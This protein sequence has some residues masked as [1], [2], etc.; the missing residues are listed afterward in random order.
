MIKIDFSKNNEPTVSNKLFKLNMILYC[1]REKIEWI[2]GIK[3]PFWASII[4]TNRCNLKCSHCYSK[5]THNIEL[6]TEEWKNKIKRLREKNIY[7]GNLTGGGEPLLRK[8]VVMLVDEYLKCYFLVTNG[9]IEIPKLNRSKAM[10]YISCEGLKENNDMVRGKGHFNKILNTISSSE[11]PVG[12]T[13]T[14]SKLNYMNFERFIRYISDYSFHPI[15]IQFYTPS[16]P[17]DPTNP[18]LLNAEEKREIIQIVEKLKDEGYQLSILYSMFEDL[19]SKEWN[20][21]CIAKWGVLNIFPDGK[22]QVGCISNFDCNECGLTC[23]LYLSYVYKTRKIIK[24]GIIEKYRRKS[25][26]KLSN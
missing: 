9:T 25:S 26:K 18:F 4:P 11:T 2:V 17:K 7:F 15:N 24:S 20:N 21:Y 14:V 23:Y 16:Y 3:H 1:L 5:N 22:E 13:H 8:D 19:I 6:S 10:V 12:I